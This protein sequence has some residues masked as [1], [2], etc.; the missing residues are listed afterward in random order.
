V[1]FGEKQSQTWLLVRLPS[2][3]MPAD[4][5]KLPEITTRAPEGGK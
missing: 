4:T 1:H 2:P 3:E 5:V